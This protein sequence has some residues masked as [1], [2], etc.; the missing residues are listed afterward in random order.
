MATPL[1]IVVKLE[2]LPMLQPLLLA[3]T[4]VI[5]QYNDDPLRLVQSSESAVPAL[6][7]A[8]L[9]VTGTEETD[10]S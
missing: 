4:D 8:L 6:R 2:D 5:L 7:D 9:A 10:A 3:A 1:A